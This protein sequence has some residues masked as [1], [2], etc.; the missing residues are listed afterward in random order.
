MGYSE[1][2]RGNESIDGSA[3]PHVPEHEQIHAHGL[4]AG[5]ALQVLRHAAVG[6]PMLA[7]ARGFKRDGCGIEIDKLANQC[8]DRLGG[9]AAG[10]PFAAS[11]N[12]ALEPQFECIYAN[13]LRSSNPASLPA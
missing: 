2:L 7:T 13:I 6:E 5:Y 4:A 11:V 8:F 12:L 1:I 3:L 10:H 9:A